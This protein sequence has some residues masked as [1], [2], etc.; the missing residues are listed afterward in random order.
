MAGLMGRWI[1]S[2]GAKVATVGLMGV[3]WVTGLMIYKEVV[4]EKAETYVKLWT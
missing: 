1:G 2:S 4:Y 3:S